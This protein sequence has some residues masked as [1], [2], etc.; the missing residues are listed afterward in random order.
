VKT[1]LLAGAGMYDNV[2][3]ILEVCCSNE[4][5][6]GGLHCSNERLGIVVTMSSNGE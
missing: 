5:V 2:I 1:A 6:D 3:A 4:E